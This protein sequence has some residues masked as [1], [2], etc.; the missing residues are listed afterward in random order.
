VAL[1]TQETI[2][3]DVMLDTAWRT[4]KIAR[5]LLDEMPYGPLPDDTIYEIRMGPQVFGMGLLEAIKEED[6]LAWSGP[7]GSDGD[8]ISGRVNTVLDVVHGSMQL[9]VLVRKL[10]LLM[11][12]NNQP[13]RLTLAWV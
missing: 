1:K 5:V 9:A 11:S 12:D 3:I 6:M 2:K 13:K 10:I 7:S 8:G 4:V